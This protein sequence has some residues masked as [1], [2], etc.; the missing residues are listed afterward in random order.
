QMQDE[1]YPEALA[2]ID[3]YLS[4]T[5]SQKP[6]NLVVKG[7]ILYRLERYPEAITVLK[8][9]ID[10]AGADARPDWLQVL[11]AAYFDSDQP[12]EAAKVAE[13]AL[14][15]SPDDKKLQMN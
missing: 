11:M 9:G 15:R 5:K 2:T 4:E 6:E 14:A 8:Q 13:S 3:R 1:K 7:N 12:A 10:A